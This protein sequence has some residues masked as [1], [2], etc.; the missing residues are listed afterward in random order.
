MGIFGQRYA[1][2]LESED[3]VVIDESAGVHE[4]EGSDAILP[5]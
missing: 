4:K 2:M 1:E 3:G 5:P